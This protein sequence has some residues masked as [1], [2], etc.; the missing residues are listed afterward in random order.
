MPENTESIN[1]AYLLTGSN[2]GDRLL[3][4]DLAREN[5]GCYCGQILQPSAIY[6]TAPW[7]KPDQ[8]PFLNQALAIS[9]ALDPVSLMKAILE[10]EKISGRKRLEKY[11]PRIIDIDILLYNDLVMERFDL[12]IPHPQL[13]NRRFA[14]EPLSEIAPR[15]IHPL[16]RKSILQLLAECR[17][18]L[19][20]KK[21]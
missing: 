3:Q 16:F 2:L 1:K 20:V 4:L 10:V 13:T 12:Q 8:A 11:G 18:P 7:G 9:T 6:E 19:N 17:D 14:L 21:I 5:I 15:L